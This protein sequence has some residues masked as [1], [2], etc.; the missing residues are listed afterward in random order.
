[1]KVRFLLISILLIPLTLWA[2]QKDEFYELKFLVYNTHGLPGIFLRDKPDIRFPEIGKKTQEYQISLLQEDY[3]HHE[4]LSENLNENSLS[5]RGRLNDQLICPFCTGSGLTTISNL[6]DKWK[7]E[8]V[9]ETFETCSGWFLGLND[10]FAYKGFQL[11]KITTPNKKNF[12]VLNT[13]MDAG[14]RNSD[15]SARKKQI[16]H[17]VT[18]LNKKIPNEALILVGDL[19]LNSKNNEDRKLFEKMKV[20]LDLKDSF[21]NIQ[22]SKKWPTL[23]Y[24][25]YRTGKKINLNVL[26][27]GEDKTFVNKQGPLSDHP[28]L[29]IKVSIL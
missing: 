4:L 12:Y 13:H 28:A 24:I 6:S 1:M 9:N 18:T 22:R 16:E 19:N 11:I 3:S 2:N 14:S 21:E 26:E 15:R 17:V 8:V 27:V 29:F 25:L 20:D 23:D 7:I 10:C 5:F